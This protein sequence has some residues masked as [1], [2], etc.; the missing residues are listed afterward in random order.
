MGASCSC[1]NTGQLSAR[2]NDHTLE[3]TLIIPLDFT[4]V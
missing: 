3:V 1:L 2:K 4:V